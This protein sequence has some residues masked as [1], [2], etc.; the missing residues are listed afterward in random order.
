[1]FILVLVA[2]S[3]PLLRAQLMHIES[4]GVI[5]SIAGSDMSLLSGANIGDAWSTSYSFVPGTLPLASSGTNWATYHTADALGEV[6]A[7]AFT[8]TTTHFALTLL[9]GESLGLLDGT[10]A[11]ADLVQLSGYSPSTGLLILTSLY[12]PV[13]TLNRFDPRVPSFA[14]SVIKLELLVLVG[15]ASA[16]VESYAEVRSLDPSFSAVP[17][18]ET[19]GWLAAFILIGAS[20]L[21]RL[22]KHSTFRPVQSESLI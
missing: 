4:S 12:Y 1:M 13:G 10:L 8:A 9:E 20:I 6:T 15:G 14:A 7:G 5:D 16:L 2:C 3:T 21:R 22:R 18:P 11:K 19:Y 17:E